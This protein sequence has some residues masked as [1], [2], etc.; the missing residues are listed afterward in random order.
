MAGIGQK[1]LRKVFGDETKREYSNNEI[2]RYG[3][4][5]F[6]QNVAYNLLCS[7]FFYFCTDVM[8]YDALVL[9]TVLAASRIWDAVND[10]IAGSVVDRITFKSGD[11]LRPYIK[12]CCIP[13]GVFV[14]ML[15][16]DLHIPSNYTFIYIIVAYFLYDFLYSFQ[17]VAQ[18]GLTARISSKPD[19]RAFAS[20][21]ARICGSMGSWPVGLITII[22]AN[23]SLLG[24]SEKTLFAIF[25]VVFGLGG[26]ILALSGAKAKERVPAK[27][28]SAGG[29]IKLLLKNKIVICIVLSNIVGNITLT[30]PA[31]Y[32]FKYMVSLDLF[33][34][35]MNGLNVNFVFGAIFGL[36]GFL[37]MFIANF[38]AK[39][40][41]GMKRILI[42]SVVMNISVRLI[43]FF[44]GYEGYK[45]FFMFGLT[46]LAG[47]PGGMT[48]IAGTVLWGDSLDYME[49]KTG[50]RN[51]GLV[52]SMQNFSG[53][54]GNAI[55]IF[56]SGLTLSILQFNGALYDQDLPQSPAFYKWIWP[57]YILAPAFG[58]VL[59]LIPI[60]F[61][62]FNEK[63]KYLIAEK[64]RLKRLGIKPRVSI[65]EG[66]ALPRNERLR[67]RRSLFRKPKEREEDF[68]WN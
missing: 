66:K 58:D 36:P 59:K 25:G 50:E 15:F 49:W 65:F 10:P 16:V 47:I 5:V 38:F 24:V 19:D 64:L 53:K 21:V 1:L 14:A 12:I 29:S 6:G 61:L 39:K 62:R 60:L 11:K 55:S 3:V 22:I 48:G 2:F 37:S 7:W 28:V 23:K 18:W 54:F 41:G 9:G 30:V 52:F 33:G 20:Q 63:Q 43:A 8:Y 26:M 67:L 68:N 17:D 27:K 56:F 35:H 57:I 34:Y 4:G 42:T 13:I 40:I 31:I 32:F 51:E 45:I 46:M 44:I